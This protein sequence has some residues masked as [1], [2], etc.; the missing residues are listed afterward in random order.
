MY[1]NFHLSLYVTSLTI[2]CAVYAESERSVVADLSPFRTNKI[3][4]V[5]A[6]A[7]SHVADKNAIKRIK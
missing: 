2:L 5:W 4:F 6:K 3:N 1:C 7:V